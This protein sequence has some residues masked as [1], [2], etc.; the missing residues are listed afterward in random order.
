MKQIVLRKS[1][2]G[3]PPIGTIGEVS[4]L[5]AARPRFPPV[6]GRLFVKWADGTTNIIPRRWVANSALEIL[7][8]EGIEQ[9]TGD[10]R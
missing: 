9:A 1:M 6:T 7:A 3:L 4:E 5:Q 10:S 2:L 8:F